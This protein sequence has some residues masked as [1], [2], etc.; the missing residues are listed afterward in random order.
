MNEGERGSRGPEGGTP[1]VLRHSL[2][3]LASHPPLYSASRGVRGG[4]E[5]GGTAG[6]GEARGGGGKAEKCPPS[7]DNSEATSTPLPAAAAAAAKPSRSLC[8]KAAPSECR[9]P[10]ATRR[11]RQ[12]PSSVSLKP[13]LPAPPAPPAPLGPPPTP[14]GPFQTPWARGVCFVRKRWPRLRPARRGL[15]RGGGGAPGTVSPATRRGRARR[16]AGSSRS[17]AGARRRRW[18]REPRDRSITGSHGARAFS[19]LRAGASAR[20]TSSGRKGPAPEPPRS[21]A[22]RALAPTVRAALVLF[23]RSPLVLTPLLPRPGREGA[24]R[25]RRRLLSRRRWW[26]DG[27]VQRL[28]P[29]PF[30]ATRATA[31][32]VSA[33]GSPSPPPRHESGFLL[34]RVAEL[35]SPSP[36]L[37]SPPARAARAPSEDAP[38]PGAAGSAEG[39]WLLMIGA[40]FY[41]VHLPLPCGPLALPR[42]GASQ[43]GRCCSCLQLTA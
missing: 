39:R 32:R 16:D 9:L 28:Q 35:S 23:L 30:K 42:A 17:T 3:P 11:R 26:P 36:H 43:P 29:T 18:Q 6:E 40:P 1:S 24:R 20:H 38:S 12:A 31:S 4:R 34:R 10:L 2:S 25:R 15:E 27:L 5:G 21:A 7:P 33:P 14:R 19:S 8:T 37:G 22:G 13:P 41:A